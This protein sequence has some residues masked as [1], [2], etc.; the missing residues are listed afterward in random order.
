MERE[1]TS[2]PTDA[3]T[4]AGATRAVVYDELPAKQRSTFG[5]TLSKAG[6]AS[7]SRRRRHVRVVAFTMVASVHE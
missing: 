2:N 3:T 1:E 4:A 5:A 7:Q 6:A